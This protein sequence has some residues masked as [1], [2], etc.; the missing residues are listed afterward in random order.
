MAIFGSAII[1]NDN[2]DFRLFGP[3]ALNIAMFA[4]IFVVFGLLIAPIYD[5]VAAVAQALPEPSFRRSGLPSF[6]GHAFGV[7]LLLS[8]LGGVG[9]VATGGGTLILPSY[10]LIV[11]PIASVLIRRRAGQFDRLSDLRGHDAAM[12]AALAVLALPVVLGVA[13][14]VMAIVDIFQAAG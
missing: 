13:F 3:P 12:R 5:W 4:S 2:P 7:V 6:A 10:V 14:N 9:I 8:A 1:K 11:V